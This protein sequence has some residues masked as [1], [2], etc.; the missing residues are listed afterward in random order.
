MKIFRLTNLADS[1]EEFTM[2][3]EIFSGME[4]P[5]KGEIIL[6]VM[7]ERQLEFQVI[8][9]PQFLFNQNALVCMFTIRR[10]DRRYEGFVV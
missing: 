8:S 5:V 4:A 2:G 6:A 9:E 1:Q 7:P 3:F 10:L